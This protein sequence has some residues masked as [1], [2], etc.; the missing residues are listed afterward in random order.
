MYPMKQMV[1]EQE[2][3][4]EVRVVAGSFDFEQ[5]QETVEVI[6]YLDFDYLKC[7]KENLD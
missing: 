6:H 4:L 3:I 2:I 1:V 7:S 5:L